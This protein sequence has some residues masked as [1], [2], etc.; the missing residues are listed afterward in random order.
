MIA[1]KENGYK[2][3]VVHED[4]CT[5]GN[6]FEEEPCQFKLIVNLIGSQ[7]SLWSRNLKND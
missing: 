6:G 4:R 3:L 7:C 5:G 2:K 1:G